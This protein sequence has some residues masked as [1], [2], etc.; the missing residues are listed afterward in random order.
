MKCVVLIIAGTRATL[1]ALKAKLERAMPELSAV[2]NF[3]V[4]YPEVTQ[5]NA[6]DSGL[7]VL[8]YIHEQCNA[9]A[10]VGK[11]ST[12]LTRQYL[13][14]LVLSCVSEVS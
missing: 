3:S 14:D 10:T 12:C 13:L 1:K 5:K 7:Y 4:V 8:S 9:T 6:F 2:A 11:F